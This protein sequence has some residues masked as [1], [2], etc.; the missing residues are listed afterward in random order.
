MK[1]YIEDSLWNSFLFFEEI[2]KVFNFSVEFSPYKFRDPISSLHNLKNLSIRA[3]TPPRGAG[4]SSEKILQILIRLR[5]K[6]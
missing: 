6:I 3:K 5:C 2:R 4:S 1:I